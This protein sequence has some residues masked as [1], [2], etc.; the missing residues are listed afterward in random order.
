M[1]AFHVMGGLLAL[2]AL[3]VSFLGVTREGFPA[4]KGSERAVM[5]VSATLVLCA[6]GSAVL[7]AVEE[8]H[9]EEEHEAAEPAALVLPR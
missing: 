3:L 6:V 2:W 5:A 8:R 1:N 7:T 4:S 9:E